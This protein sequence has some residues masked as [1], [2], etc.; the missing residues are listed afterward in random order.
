MY[1]YDIAKKGAE[2][3]L[4]LLNASAKE[5]VT[6][7]AADVS[8]SAPTADDSVESANTQ[9]TL[10]V[11]EGSAVVNN[12]SPT[13]TRHYTR[14][15]LS[16]VVDAIGATITFQETL[17]AYDDDTKK[18]A[19]FVEAT[20]IALEAGDVTIATDEDAASVTISM[21]ATHLGLI[22]SAKMMFQKPAPKLPNLDESFPG[23]SLQGFEAPAGAAA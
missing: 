15:D 10:S 12:E 22:G 20:G 3:M 23:E 7:T 4:A 6:V 9:V 2:N 17:E 16:A 11:V 21:V 18:L 5:G 19:K 14:L 13:V 1:K 8:W